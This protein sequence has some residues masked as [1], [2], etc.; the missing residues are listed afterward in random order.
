MSKSSIEHLLYNLSVV[1][2]RYYVIF[3]TALGQL[4][5]MFCTVGNDIDYTSSRGLYENDYGTG[6][7]YFI[8]EHHDFDFD[9]INAERETKRQK[10]VAEY[11][12]WKSIFGDNVPDEIS[13]QFSKDLAELAKPF[14]VLDEN[15][16]FNYIDMAREMVEAVEKQAKDEPHGRLTIRTPYPLSSEYSNI[17]KMSQHD[18]PL[19]VR[20]AVAMSKAWIE[21]LEH[22]AQ[23]EWYHTDEEAE[24]YGGASQYYSLSYI[25]TCIDN[26]K[27]II[28][29]LEIQND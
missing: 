17:S 29:N 6:N 18:N 28:N 24:M 23:A 2:Y 25:N 3:D 1:Q 22:Y 20:L 13:E 4:D 14:E 9:K 26:F 10:L 21:V 11:E 15:Y 8:A 27:R 5:H 12:R 16:Y 7:R 19:M